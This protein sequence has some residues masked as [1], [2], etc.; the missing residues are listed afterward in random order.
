[1]RQLLFGTLDRLVL[2]ILYFVFLYNVRK[3]HILYLLFRLFGS[4]SMVLAFRL[5]KN[6]VPTF[7]FDFVF[8]YKI[9]SRI[10]LSL[11]SYLK[12]LRL[13][14]QI[15]RLL[16]SNMSICLIFL[17]LRLFLLRLIFL[18]FFHL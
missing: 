4:P 12:C 7:R 2:R 14:L 6:V 5:C 8:F 17:F 9:L 11:L 18:L 3:F 10:L 13:L 1:M 16:A 15:L